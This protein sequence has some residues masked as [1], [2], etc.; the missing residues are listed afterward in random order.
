MRII[1]M[2]PAR[3]GST[4]VK[5]KNLRLLDGRPLIQ[6]VV[7][8]ALGSN[9]IDEL[10]INSESVRFKPI[11][12]NSDIKFYQRPIHLS[13]DTATNDEF[14]LDFIDNIDCDILIQLL[15]TSPFITSAEIDEFI[16]TMLDGDYETMISVTN[17]QIEAIFKGASINFDMTKPTP[18]SQLLEPVQS[19]ACSL[20]GWNVDTFRANIEKYNAAYHGGIDKKGYYVLKGYSTIDIDNEEDFVLAEVIASALKNKPA[21]PE[22]YTPD[23]NYTREVDVPSIL[24]KDGVEIN[25]LFDVNNEVVALAD[26]LKSMPKD[27]SWSKRIIDTE[28][29]S[30][31]IIC[32]M[33]GEGNRRHHHPDWNEWWYIVEGEWEWWI[34]GKVSKVVKGD[35]VFMEKNRKHKITASGS[36]RAIRMAVSRADVEHVYEK[37]IL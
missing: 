26:V 11:A 17:I 9:L 18:P 8:A 22:Y 1:G 28:S 20:M 7:D 15:P 24:A 12:E 31:T 37:G 10:Y 29:N 32:Q 4:R 3:L 5:N 6:H 21:K 19:Y 27:V 25:D 14:S 23:E 34:E 33:P 36:S 35:I 2:I 13:S 30:M 16:Q